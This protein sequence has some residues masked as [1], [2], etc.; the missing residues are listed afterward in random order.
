MHKRACAHTLFAKRLSLQ[1]HA[2]DCSCIMVSR[3]ANNK[4]SYQSED[5]WVLTRGIWNR[6]KSD[7]HLLISQLGDRLNSPRKKENASLK[8]FGRWIFHEAAKTDSQN[9]CVSLDTRASSLLT[10]KE[11]QSGTPVELLGWNHSIHTCLRLHVSSCHFVKLLSWGVCPSTANSVLPF[12]WRKT[13]A[14]K[15]T[16]KKQKNKT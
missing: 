2:I 10:R 13:K 14:Q 7:F 16:I 9:L 12:C 11:N 15:E 6:N 5:Q 4:Y 8:T 3:K 1:L